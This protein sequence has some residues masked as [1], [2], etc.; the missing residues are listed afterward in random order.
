MKTTQVIILAYSQVCEI[1]NELSWANKEI[2]VFDLPTFE[3]SP[4]LKRKG[5]IN[6]FPRVKVIAK[7]HHV[8]VG[9]LGR[10][11]EVFA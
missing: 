11:S 3:S 6:Q 10:T 9:T 8:L 4:V 1:L 7:Q 5:C 2:L